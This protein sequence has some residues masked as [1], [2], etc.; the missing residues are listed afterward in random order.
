MII[1]PIEYPTQMRASVSVA[2]FSSV[3]SDA[4]NV[5]Q[6]AQRAVIDFPHYPVAAEVSF[7]V[8]PTIT[9]DWRYLLWA[10]VKLPNH[11]DTISVGCYSFAE[12]I[13]RTAQIVRRAQTLASA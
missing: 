6:T 12:L 2:R 1:G 8:L 4:G 10:A 11:Q 13:E 5:K 3:I 7:T 9:P